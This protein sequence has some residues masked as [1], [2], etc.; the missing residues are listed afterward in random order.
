MHN[1]VSDSTRV[2]RTAAW[3]W[4]VY[5]VALAIIDR[6]IYANQPIS[7]I[8]WYHFIN[9]IPALIF[10][11][12]SRSSWLKNKANTIAPSMILMITAGPILVYHL[13]DLRLPPAPLSNIE[14]MVLRQLPIF[15]IGLVLVAWHYNLLTIVLY[16]LATNLFEFV[17]VFGFV[18]MDQARLSAFYFIIIIRMV[19][20]VVIGIFINQLITR[21]RIQQESLISANNQLTH[22]ASTLESLTVS[23]ERN[24]MSRELHDTVVHTLSGLSVQLETA[25]AY[26]DVDPGTAR[27]LVDR[28]LEI[29]RTGLQETR[30]ALKALRASPLEDLGLVKAIHNMIEVAA[31]RGRLVLD[32][33]LP[34]RDLFL[35]PDVEQCLYRITQEAVENVI[36][37]ANARHLMVKFDVKQKDLD[38]LIQDDGIGFNPE[39]SLPS[40]HFGLVGMRERTDLVGGE[41]SI[42]SQP[43]CGTTIRLIIRGGVE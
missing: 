23:R 40:G 12:L 9:G 1:E 16:S 22:Y 30:L 17:I 15:F 21:L 24:R 38:L 32:V 31:E 28:S 6:F 26:L 7:P 25:K 14:G 4:L 19:C 3:M 43:N 8:L 34:D 13:F 29:T 5:L 27:N 42:H 39:N 18:R 37:H 36:H 2:F 35:S 10:L 20:F 11:G 33:S 41:L